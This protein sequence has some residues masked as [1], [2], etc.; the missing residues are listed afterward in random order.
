MKR[1]MEFEVGCKKRLNCGCWVVED[2]VRMEIGSDFNARTIM[3][4]KMN[5]RFE[6]FIL[7][8]LFVTIFWS[9]RV[10][11]TYPV[12]VSLYIINYF[13]LN[14]LYLDVYYRL[15]VLILITSYVSYS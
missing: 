1:A 9:I 10:T 4:V 2:R 14:A 12:S 11:I 15:V 7:P 5:I 3:G 8:L 6:H 13:Q